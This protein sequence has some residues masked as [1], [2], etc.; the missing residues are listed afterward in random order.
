MFLLANYDLI[1][2]VLAMKEKCFSVCSQLVFSLLVPNIFIRVI[3]LFPWNPWMF[4]NV[5]EF[6][7]VLNCSWKK[8][9]FPPLVLECSWIFQFYEYFCIA[10]FMF[11]VHGILNDIL[12]IF[13]LRHLNFLFLSLKTN[14]LFLKCSWI[15]RKIWVA[16]LNTTRNPRV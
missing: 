7:L 8:C 1:L 4:L 9:V 16:T 2:L 11:Q 3:I 5:L 14:I 10:C 15:V 13:N 12:Y 6:N